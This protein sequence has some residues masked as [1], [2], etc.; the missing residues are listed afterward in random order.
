MGAAHV[1]GKTT[2]NTKKPQ[3]TFAAAVDILPYYAKKLSRSLD[4][5]GFVLSF[6]GLGRSFRN[7]CSFFPIFPARRIHKN[8]LKR[9]LVNEIY[10]CHRYA[11]CCF[12]YAFP[13]RTFSSVTHTHTFL[14]RENHSDYDTWCFGFS[15][16]G[17]AARLQSN[18][19]PPRQLSIVGRGGNCNCML[20][21]SETLVFRFSIFHFH[22]RCPRTLTYL[23]T[24]YA[25]CQEIAAAAWLFYYFP[26]NRAALFLR[27]AVN[28]M[29]R[30]AF[31][32][33]C[34]ISLVRGL[35]VHFS[36]VL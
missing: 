18:R 16:A 24:L 4:E 28:D 34:Q 14:G 29:L 7:G 10:Y 20:S 26:V 36:S 11:L 25:N 9:Q 23:L 1:G 27:P 21:N 6:C 31:V 35:P 2:H 12:S 13:I 5:R 8:S 32:T 15:L 17:R 30:A 3:P 19:W 22:L 33:F